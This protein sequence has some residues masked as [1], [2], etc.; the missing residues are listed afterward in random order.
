VDECI[1][2]SITGT[3]FPYYISLST[4]RCSCCNGALICT[5]QTQKLGQYSTSKEWVS[6]HSYVSHD[7]YLYIWTSHELYIWL[8]SL[9]MNQP[10]M[11]ESQTLHIHMLAMTCISTYERVTNSIYDLYLSTYDWL[12]YEIVTNSTYSYVSH[13]LYLYIWTS[14]ELYIWLVSLH[15]NESRNAH[16]WMSHE[17]Y[18]WLVSLHMNESRNAHIWMHM[19]EPRTL[20]MTCIS[21]EE[22]VSTA[23]IST[24][25][26][27]PHVSANEWVMSH[28][29][30]WLIH[31]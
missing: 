16:I 23:R 22:W 29:S 3:R 25:V 26:H 9:Y 24:P 30:S 28:V 1:C 5:N 10:H 13:D 14:H 4:M 21:S 6:A 20:R 19:N 12:T 27:V 15:M 31:M 7:L 18:V 11:Y 8:I 2:Y 17:L